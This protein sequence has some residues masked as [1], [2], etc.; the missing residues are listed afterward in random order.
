[1]S[2]INKVLYNVDQRTDNVAENDWLWMA[3]HNIGLDDDLEH[4]GVIGKATTTDAHGKK[5]CGIAPLD[6]D[7]KIPSICLPDLPA[8]THGNITNDGKI[9]STSGLPLVTTTGGL[10]TTGAFGTAAGEFASG[11]H[12]HGNISNDGKI[13]ST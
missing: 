8:H 10:V 1:M 12:T 5:T 9:G 4:G 11:N 13:G 6:G 3:R 7:G 2:K